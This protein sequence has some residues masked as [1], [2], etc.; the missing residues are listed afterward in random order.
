MRRPSEA[1]AQRTAVRQESLV[2]PA[3]FERATYGLGIRCS[4]L[5]SY[6]AIWVGSYPEFWA[7]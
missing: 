3:R 5:L 1:S 2:T 4:I 6:G 7:G